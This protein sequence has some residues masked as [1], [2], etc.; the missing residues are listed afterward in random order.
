MT[1]VK[2]TAT[3]EDA[4]DLA[5]RE[6]NE[7]FDYRALRNG[8]QVGNISMLYLDRVNK[9]AIEIYSE[10]VNAE[11]LEALE[12]LFDDFKGSLKKPENHDAFHVAQAAIK[13]ARG[14]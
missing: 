8:V 9:R 5:A 1:E 7:A 11:L 2:K 3:I 12:L 10:Q 6:W 4:Q 14:L 13:R